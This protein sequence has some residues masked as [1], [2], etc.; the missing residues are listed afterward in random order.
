MEAPKRLATP[1]QEAGDAS[2]AAR[3][4]VLQLLSVLGQAVL[5]V[6]HILVARLFGKVV[7]GPYQ[8]AVAVVEVLG[9]AAPV[10]AIGGEHRF[11]AA[12][13][14]AGEPELAQ[15]ALGTGLRLTALAAGALAVALGL[16]SPLVA[17]VWHDPSLAATLPIMAPVV[18]FSAL[19]MVLVAATLGAKVARMNLY[20]RGIAEPLLLLGGA[21]V[22]WRLGGGLGRLM[23]AHLASSA[24]VAVL[25]VAACAR[26]FGWS[27]LGGAITAPRHPA[28]LRFTLPLGASDLMS[29]ILQRADTF[30]IVTL[31]G[32]DAFAVYAAAE[33]VTRAIANARYVFDHI[34][35]PVISE[36]MHAGDR[37]RVRYNLAL[38]TRWVVT[39]AAPLA[40]TLIVL[41]RE[42]LGLYGADFV[43]GTGTF[44][45]VALA[46]FVN[47]A[48]GLTPYVIA[49]GGRSRLLFINNVGAAALNVALCLVLIPRLGIAGAATAVLVSIA[50]FQ[51][52]LTVETWVLER[53]HP[54]APPLLKPLAGA[55]A[56]F[57]CQAAVHALALPAGARVV[58]VIVV[59]AAS[60]LGALLAFGLE[61]EEQRFLRGLTRRLRAPRA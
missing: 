47:A 28:F 44:V 9:R 49:M 20:V 5:P 8:A 51:G 26:V 4:G 60:Y 40:A 54:F 52:A 31:A 18:L 57:G 45:I 42:L 15:R 37:A 55:L 23:V 10:G 29:A 36:A 59:G 3:S 25:A 35:A 22:A 1:A 30:L 48:L 46:H 17:R 43:S 61:P 34:L 53:V 58:L 12:H 32:F 24:V 7:F 14:A 6:T 56:A 21:L 27:Y 13:R 50:A 38:V 39:A 33:F 19:T 16:G 2:H 11:I 41:R